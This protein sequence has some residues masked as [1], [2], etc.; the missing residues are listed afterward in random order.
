[1][2]AHPF[3][4][5]DHVHGRHNRPQVAGC[6]LLRSYQ[7]QALLLDF[8]SFGIDLAIMRDDRVRRFRIT[9]TQRSD[10]LHQGRIDLV[11]HAQD[12]IFDMPELAVQSYAWR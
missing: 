6:R 12:L 7:A 4:V 5:V 3:K 1:M 2:V 8:K 10:R 9:F 11:T